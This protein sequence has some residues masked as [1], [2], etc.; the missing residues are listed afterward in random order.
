[1][2]K[3]ILL[4]VFT[5]LSLT[6]GHSQSNWRIGLNVGIPTGDVHDVSTFNFGGDVAY[7]FDVTDVL[8]VGPLVGYSH[9]F[10]EKDFEDFSFVPLAASGRF[11]FSDAFF[12]GADLGYAIAVDKGNDGGFFY[13]PKLGYNFGNLALIGSYSGIE[14]KNNGLSS[15]F[16]SINLGIELGF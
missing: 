16:G 4:I 5:V 8:S 3:L 15:T 12:V 13:R 10:G 2:K 9:F 11:S 14:V 1:M 7:L 6:V